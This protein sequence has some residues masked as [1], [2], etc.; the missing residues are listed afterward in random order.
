HYMSRIWLEKITEPVTLVVFDNHTDM[1]PPAF[2]G[3]LSC[4]G[5]IEA[6]LTEIPLLQ[7][8][9]LIGPD[10]EALFQVE[11]EL[12]ERTD[13]LSRERLKAMTEEQRAEF[14]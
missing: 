10:E 4:G 3:L 5:W 1:Q 13:F 7:R 12:R 9:I 8:V 11:P 6:A 2:G 14:L